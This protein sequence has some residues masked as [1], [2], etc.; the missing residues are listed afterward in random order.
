MKATLRSIRAVGTLESRQCTLNLGA[1]DG[2]GLDLSG[3]ELQVE[4]FIDGATGVTGA[5]PLPA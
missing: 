4:S 5:M 3:G 2:K 1:L